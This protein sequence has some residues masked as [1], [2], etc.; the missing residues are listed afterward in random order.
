VSPGQVRFECLELGTSLGPGHVAIRHVL[1][2]A[3]RC[4]LAGDIRDGGL[5]ERGCVPKALR[6]FPA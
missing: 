2:C 4:E 3:P 5:D 6:D 1:G